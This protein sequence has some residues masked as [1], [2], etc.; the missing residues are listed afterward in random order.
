MTVT[1]LKVDGVGMLR[2]EHAEVIEGPTKPV[3]LVG[4]PIGVVSQPCGVVVTGCAGGGAGGARPPRLFL[5]EGGLG[6]TVAPRAQV[7]V[8]LTA[9]KG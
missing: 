3:K 5:L 2:Q 1:R 7:D 8:T 6:I 9:T 4:V